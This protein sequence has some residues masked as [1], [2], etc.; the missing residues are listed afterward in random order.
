V[1]HIPFSTSPRVAFAICALLPSWVVQDVT[2]RKENLGLEPDYG[3]FARFNFQGAPRFELAM[4]FR[5]RCRYHPF[6]SVGRACAL[7]LFTV[8]HLDNHPI[9]IHIVCLAIVG[10]LLDGLKRSMS[11]D[12]VMIHGVRSFLPSVGT[13]IIQHPQQLVNTFTQLIE[14]N[15]Q[16]TYDTFIG[17]VEQLY[18]P[19]DLT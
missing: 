13:L 10:C 4:L 1:K 11:Y 16:Q 12:V 15:T 18:H 8:H 7:Y 6:F 3:L 17:Q 9:G 19:I 14:H 5:L 2:A